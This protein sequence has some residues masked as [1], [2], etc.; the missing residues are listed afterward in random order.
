M[1]EIETR[2]DG[3][4][5]M[6][7]AVVLLGIGF[8]LGVLAAVLVL[9]E[10][11]RPQ[12]VGLPA[13]R[14][15]QGTSPESPPTVRP[16]EEYAVDKEAV[17]ILRRHVILSRQSRCLDA[18]H[19]L[20]KRNYPDLEY[21]NLL[22][23]ELGDISSKRFKTLSEAADALEKFQIEV[24]GDEGGPDPWGRLD[25]VLENDCYLSFHAPG[26]SE[27]P[28]LTPFSLC[29]WKIKGALCVNN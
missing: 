18:V 23:K 6:R 14:E 9:R 19:P 8:C 12:R 29:R 20:D 17:E 10:Q 16:E 15:T 13:Q 11:H 28:D 26:N 4:S 1:A 22:M 7:R 21:R 3:R 24:M 2:F 27:R 25:P 5:S